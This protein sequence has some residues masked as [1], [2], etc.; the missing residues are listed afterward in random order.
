MDALL[1]AGSCRLFSSRLPALTDQSPGCE[2]PLLLS[3]QQ[4]LPQLTT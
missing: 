1:L 3:L 4:F 2:E